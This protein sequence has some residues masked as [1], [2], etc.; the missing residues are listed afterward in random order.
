LVWASSAPVH[1][2]G[3][4]LAR[5]S[6]EAAFTFNP[7]AVSPNAV[8]ESRAIS[9][10]RRYAQALPSPRQVLAGV[11]ESVY[12]G[13]YSDETFAPTPVW[14]VEYTGPGVNI[15]P[16]PEGLLSTGPQQYDHAEAVVV[17]AFSGRFLTEMTIQPSDLPPS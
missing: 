15:G 16:G 1:H 10:A 12:Y 17:D 7:T 4:S 2:S 5:S 14:L 13:N 11:T 3:L 8:P 9:T 6:T